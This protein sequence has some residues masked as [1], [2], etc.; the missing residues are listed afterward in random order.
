MLVQRKMPSR[1]HLNKI[2]SLDVTTPDNKTG[3]NRFNNSPH[4][5]ETAST[6]TSEVVQTGSD[7]LR[8]DL[9]GLKTGSEEEE[10]AEDGELTEDEE[11]SEIR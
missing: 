8:G 10:S 5:S 7:R 6:P 11:M 3:S 1:R 2:A 4:M 9:P